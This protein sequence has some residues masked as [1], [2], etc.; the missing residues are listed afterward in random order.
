M[1]N[2]SIHIN[3]PFVFNGHLDGLAG[4]LLGWTWTPLVIFLVLMHPEQP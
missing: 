1:I 2:E 4:I 3:Y